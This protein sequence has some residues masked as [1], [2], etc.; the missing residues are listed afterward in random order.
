MSNP[1]A[2]LLAGGASRRMGRE[3][4][5]LE[6]GGETLISR[7]LRQLRQIGVTNAIAVCNE[8][9]LPAL[10][11]LARCVLQRAPEMSGAALTGLQAAGPAE[12]VYLVSVNDL[13]HDDDYRRIE[14][15]GRAGA[16][17]VIP[18]RLLD[19]TFAGGRLHF[20]PGTDRVR[21][22]QEKPPGGCPPGSAA[23]IMIHRLAGAPFLGALAERLAAGCEYEAALT[24]LIAEGV[25]AIAVWVDFCAAIKTPE[26]Y[27]R[28]SQ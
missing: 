15:A 3:K 9:N 6:A 20:F 21:A 16:A 10:R 25:E 23:N 12:A 28:L 26:D 18:S 11:G 4:P 8:R 7:H 1:T 14:E 19:R 13:V 22:I 2:I 5:L 17:I 27:Q 24:S